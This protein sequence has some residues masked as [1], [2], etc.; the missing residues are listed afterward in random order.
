[1]VTQAFSLLVDVR[2]AYRDTVTL[3]A[4]AME[5]ENPERLAHAERVAHLASS[6][7]REVG[8]QG[9]RLEWLTYAALFHDMDL[10]GTDKAETTQS[11]EFETPMS[12]P[13]SG[14]VGQ[15]K[16]LE[17]IA[18][19]LGIVNAG[20]ETLMSQSEFDII[21]AYIVARASEIDDALN[22]RSGDL[23]R[24]DGVGRRLYADRRRELDSRIG[25]SATRVTAAAAKANAAR[26]LEP[27]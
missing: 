19:I 2:T 25:R 24:S 16:F 22:E 14:V 1:V 27:R 17:P 12:S 26:Y 8:L 9:Q 4:R 20:G 21:A 6:T 7:G 11:M 13:G 5:A 18:R 23:R 10:M 3:L 15:V